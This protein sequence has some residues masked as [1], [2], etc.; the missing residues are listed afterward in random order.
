MTHVVLPFGSLQ[1]PLNLTEWLE[2]NI[3]SNLNS[4]KV[5]FGESVSVLPPCTGWFAGF[6]L[7]TYFQEVL[8]LGGVAWVQLEVCESV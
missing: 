1:T 8:K 5:D 4:Y 3:S 2:P 7:E 6:F